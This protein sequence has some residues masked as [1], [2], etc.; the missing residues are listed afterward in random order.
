MM[1]L[2]YKVSCKFWGRS[3]RA[4]FEE[5]REKRFFACKCKYREE[6]VNSVN[7]SVKY[8]YYFYI[9]ILYFI[10]YVCIFIHPTCARCNWKIISQHIYL[11]ALFLTLKEQ[12]AYNFAKPNKWAVLPTV[13]TNFPDI[14]AIGLC[15]FCYKITRH[16]NLFSESFPHIKTL[17][18][19]QYRIK[20]ILKYYFLVLIS[21][22]LYSY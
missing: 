18:L 20:N 1:R 9:T 19:L 4:V 17:H 5:T 3:S 12:F 22:A 11:D 10:V 16:I 6:Y 15:S 14:I 7:R 13:I 2:S 8:K 21:V